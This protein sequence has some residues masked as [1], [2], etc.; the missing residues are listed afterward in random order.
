MPLVLSV[1]AEKGSS[2]L[3]PGN[4]ISVSIIPAFKRVYQAVA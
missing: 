2:K 1:A 4:M 3:L